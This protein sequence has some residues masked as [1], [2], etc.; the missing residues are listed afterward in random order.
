MIENLNLKLKFQIHFH[1]IVAVLLMLL[2][3]LSPLKRLRHA[4]DKHGVGREPGVP[5]HSMPRQLNNKHARSVGGRQW[6]Q[7]NS[8]LL[9]FYDPSTFHRGKAISQRQ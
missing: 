6:Q 2:L 9:L 4:D 5:H 1:I 8:R 3:L 7:G